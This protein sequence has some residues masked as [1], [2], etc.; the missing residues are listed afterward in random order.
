MTKL[1]K[2]SERSKL[3]QYPDMWIDYDDV[4]ECPGCNECF[5]NS[6]L[7]GIGYCDDCGSEEEVLSWKQ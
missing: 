4:S 6:E 3:W 1:E 7:D 5:D 2:I